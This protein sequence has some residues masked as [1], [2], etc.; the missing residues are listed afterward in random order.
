[1]AKTM[2]QYCKAYH[3]PNFREYKNWK[4]RAENTRL[5]K[6]EVDGKEIK[7]PRE[8]KEGDFLYLHENYIVTDGI[9][10]DEN[11]IFDDVTDEWKEFCDNTL[12]FEVPDFESETVKKPE[13][14]DDPEQK[15]Q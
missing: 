7:A 8:L 9:Y 1:M 5:E 10:L 6:K 14:K 3:I 13:Q 11:I 2:G 12:K 15:E 4:E